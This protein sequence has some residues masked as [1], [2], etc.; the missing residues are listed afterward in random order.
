MTGPAVSRLDQARTFIGDLAR[1]FSIYVTSTSA[2]IATVVVAFKVDSFEGA[3]IFIGA[4]YAGIAGIYGWKSWEQARAG[5]HAAE[6]EIARTV[7][8]VAAG[9]GVR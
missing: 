9:E 7:Q 4:V 6:V 8:P 1:P 3:A 5:R 2:A